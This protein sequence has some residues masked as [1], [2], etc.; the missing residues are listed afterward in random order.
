MQ[1]Q[2]FAQRSAYL[3]LGLLAG[4][5][6]SYFWPHQPAQAI[7]NSRA[8]KFEMFTVPA[9]AAGNEGVFVLD[10]VTGQLRGAVLDPQA[11]SFTAFYFR[12]IAQDFNLDELGGKPQFAILSGRTQLQNRPGMRVQ[13][14]PGVIFVA[15]LT[16]GIVNSYAFTWERTT[17]P[18]AP[19]QLVFVDKFPFR[20]ADI[21]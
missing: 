6:V 21:Q 9:A 2:K 5:A 12:N 16:S 10:H 4:L 1:N 14:A 20:Q 18:V 3:G 15:E 11:H 13:T 8:E 17:R 7:T 19:Q